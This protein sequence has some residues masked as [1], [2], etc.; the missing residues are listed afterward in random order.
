[1]SDFWRV[2]TYL[3]HEDFKILLTNIWWPLQEFEIDHVLSLQGHNDPIRHEVFV[4]EM[5][6][7]ENPRDLR[8]RLQGE[9]SLGSISAN[10]PRAVVLV[11]GNYRTQNIPS[12]NFLQLELDL[13]A[14]FDAV[15]SIW[16][17]GRKC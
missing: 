8:G 5:N 6:R 13:V 14:S 17:F 10:N 7:F 9:A 3:D 4:L 15:M 11:C 2:A 12:E 1:M 16:N